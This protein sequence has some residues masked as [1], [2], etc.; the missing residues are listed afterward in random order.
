MHARTSGLADHLAVDEL[1]CIRI[2][3][4]IV[5]RLNWRKRGPEP[6]TGDPAPPLPRSPTTSSA[7]RPPTCASP[8]TPATCSPGCSTAPSF[9]EFK[10]LYGPSLVTGWGELW[11][12]PVGVLANARGVLF[13]EE[14]D[15]ATQFIQ[16]A[17]QQSTSRCCSC[18]TP[19]ATWSARTTSSAA[20]SRT[21]R[22]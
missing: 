9:D 11:G 13:N 1:D 16:L 15:K 21:A 17:N 19:P 10:P 18:R 12:Y 5:R 4:E 22:R 7:S 8:S 3:R 20:W 14:S 2:G 6:R